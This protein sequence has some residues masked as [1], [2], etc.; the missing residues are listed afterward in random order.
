MEKG[1][2][3]QLWFD[4]KDTGV[5]CGRPAASLLNHGNEKRDQH[6]RQ[7]D[8]LQGLRGTWRDQN[9]SGW[10]EAWGRALVWILSQG[11]HALS[12]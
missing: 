6:T 1:T 5:G 2:K 8:R 12:T 3:V 7:V 11:R 4:D 9:W 10:G